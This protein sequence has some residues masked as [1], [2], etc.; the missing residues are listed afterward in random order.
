[1][2]KFEINI[3]KVKFDVEFFVVFFWKL[4]W[5]YRILFKVKS[6][7]LKVEEKLIKL[8]V[9]LDFIFVRFF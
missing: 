4:E 2:L 7:E 9:I 5:I 1:M 6:W 8:L 3:L